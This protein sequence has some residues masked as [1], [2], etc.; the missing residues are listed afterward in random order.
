MT[1]DRLGR[2]GWLFHGSALRSRS[3]DR[4]GHG[5]S[6]GLWMLFTRRWPARYLG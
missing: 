1:D 3:R 6:G 5:V 2:E 4:G